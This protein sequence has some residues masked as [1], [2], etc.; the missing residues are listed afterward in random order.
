M[1]TVANER[2]KLTAG[3]LNT[4][5]GFSLTA[6]AIAP[7]IAV[8]YGVIAAPSL[9]AATLLL[10]IAIWMVVGMGLQIYARRV[11]GGLKP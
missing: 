9:G 5:A 6:G 7:L 1:S 8:S 3:L 11:L 2:T 4:V 10:I